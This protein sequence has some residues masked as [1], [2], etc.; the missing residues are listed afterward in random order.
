MDSLGFLE[1]NV[2]GYE[3][4]RWKRV[5]LSNLLRY[6]EHARWEFAMKKGSPLRALFTSNAFLVVRSQFGELHAP[7]T[8]GDTLR[9]DLDIAHVGG[10]SLT[11]VQTISKR[12]LEK[13]QPRIPIATMHVVTVY[14]GPDKRPQRLPKWFRDQ[15][16]RRNPPPESMGLEDPPQGLDGFSLQ[17]RNSDIDLL[18]H[19]NHAR[20]VDFL[21]DARAEMAALGRLKGPGSHPSAP[22]THFAIEYLRE[23]RPHDSLIGYAWNGS[24]LQT[25]HV[26]GLVA[27]EDRPRF[28]GVLG[29]EVDETISRHTGS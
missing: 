23:L 28:R 3:L 1:T 14:V 4:D 17:I 29:F 24:N 12:A 5:P 10:S 22:P 26:A 20:Y 13:D 9:I 21:Q 19:V 7:A 6:A 18:Q 25:L 11:F 8:L 27:G 15:V 2:R 16:G